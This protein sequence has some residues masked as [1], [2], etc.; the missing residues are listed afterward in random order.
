VIGEAA[1][2]PEQLAADVDRFAAEQGAE[3]RARP[4]RELG[5]VRP[6]QL[7]RRDAQHGRVLEGRRW[8]TGTTG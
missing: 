4:S 2:G 6:A 3:D 1:A 5:E 7:G 8:R